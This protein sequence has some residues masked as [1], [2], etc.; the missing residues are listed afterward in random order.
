MDQA[1]TPVVNKRSWGHGPSW[2]AVAL[3]L[4][5]LGVAGLVTGFDMAFYAEFGGR[6]G[7]EQAYSCT[8]QE[9]ESCISPTLI[10]RQAAREPKL[11]SK[12]R[13]VGSGLASA[14]LLL[15]VAGLASVGAAVVVRR[16]RRG[17]SDAVAFVP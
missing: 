15:F 16:R 13:S 6:E 17:G 8:P 3:V 5:A 7:P 2:G 9:D 10:E 14:G 1:T 12:L 4:V 11:M